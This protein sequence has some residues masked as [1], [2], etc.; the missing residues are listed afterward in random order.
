MCAFSTTD[1]S[2]SKKGINMF[3][4]Y[5]I[6]NVEY[7]LIII[8]IILLQYYYF[9]LII[10]Y[11]CKAMKVRSKKNNKQYKI[12]NIILKIIYSTIINKLFYEYY[13]K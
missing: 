10:D 6:R 13:N 1:C 9:L 11:F 5:N 2:V 4:C 12:R 8:M 7:L 3:I